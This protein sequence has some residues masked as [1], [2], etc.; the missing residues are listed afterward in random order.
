MKQVRL[1]NMSSGKVSW[2]ATNHSG[3]PGQESEDHRLE[4]SARRDSCV[5][6]ASRAVGFLR[7]GCIQDL[8]PE[9]TATG[10]L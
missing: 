5:D 6:A 10:R 1:V 8:P 2:E 9:K 3:G 7:Q 4:S